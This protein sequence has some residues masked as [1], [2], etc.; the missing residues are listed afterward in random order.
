MWA[1]PAS[2]WALSAFYIMWSSLKEGMPFV[3]CSPRTLAGPSSSSWPPRFGIADAM[4]R[5]VHRNLGLAGRRD[6]A[7]GQ[8][9]PLSSSTAVMCVSWYGP[10]N[11][12]N[13]GIATRSHADAHRLQCG[14]RL[15]RQSGGTG[16]RA[17]PDLNI[18]SSN[19]A[20]QCSCGP[21]STA[22]ELLIPGDIVM[23]PC[24]LRHHPGSYSGRDLPHGKRHVLMQQR[25]WRHA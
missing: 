17:A 11:V 4:A 6:H 19:P 12:A 10:T 15:R 21:L 16:G 2:C 20:R 5:R 7:G 14:H 24:L 22:K 3:N 9:K 13:N 23:Q 1:P 18:G 8:G 25:V